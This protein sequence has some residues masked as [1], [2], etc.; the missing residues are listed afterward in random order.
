RGFLLKNK[1]GDVW[2]WDF[3]QAGMGL[4]DFTNEDATEW[5]LQK[6][7][8][9]LDMGVDCFKTD[10]GERVPTDV[11]WHDGS[12]PERMHN[13]YTYLYNRAVF[14]LLQKKRGANE[15]VVFA[16]SATAGGQNFPV[17]WG[18]D[19]EA[20]YPSMAE[21]IRGGLSLAF[22]GFPFWS[23]DISGFS[24]K[25]TAD[26]YKRWV[27]F[28]LFSTH[29]R[30]HGNES[31]RVPWFFGDEASEVLKFFTQWKH[32]LMPYIYAQ[33][34][35]ACE[36]GLP[37]MRPMA[38]Q[39][40]NDPACAYLDKQYCFGESLVVAPILNDCGS[41][42]Y[43][44]PEGVYTHLFTGETTTG[45]FYKTETYDYFGLPV[46]VAPN[47]LL[48]LG[49]GEAGVEYN[50]AENA[51]IHVYG[52]IETEIDLYDVKGVKKL[53]IFAKRNGNRISF[54]LNNN[55]AGLSFVLHGICGVNETKNCAAEKH[56]FGI[57]I[58]AG[59]NAKHISALADWKL[60]TIIYI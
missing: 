45:G 5:Y 32:R 20:H 43:Y 36:T 30:L 56:K 41:A 29:S 10:F 13:Y 38:L 44:L 50:Y 23:H 11:M 15:A 18:G 59:E 3:W 51:E 6:L 22:C 7:S 58:I 42:E 57:K 25:A 9:L 16:R 4:V 47:T 17:H 21:T 37:V 14:G 48:P 55:H 2:Q 27:A 60:K 35:K 52:L 46:W 26:L 33:S 24:S 28:G 8:A 34:A 39:F 12:D 54:T 19:S 49:D 31:Y 53:N 1:N 40:E